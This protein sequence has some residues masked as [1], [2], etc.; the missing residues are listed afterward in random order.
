MEPADKIKLQEKAK[1]GNEA[2]FLLV[3]KFSKR[4]LSDVESDVLTRLNK[5]RDAD[6]LMKIQADYHAALK[7]HEN[8]SVIA[9]DGKMAAKKLHDD[10]V[11]E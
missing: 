2:A 5:A 10:Q 11:K 1:E 4:W 3:E 6:E 8:L 7:F 9:I